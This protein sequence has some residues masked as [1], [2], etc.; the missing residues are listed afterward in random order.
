MTPLHTLLH[1]T[2]SN[3]TT[4]NHTTLHFTTLHYTSLHLLEPQLQLQLDS[5]P[6][7][8]TSLRYTSLHYIS[9]HYTNY[10]Y[11]H[12]YHYAHLHCPTLDYT[13]LS[14]IS[15]RYTSYT[16]TNTTATALRYLQHGPTT[17]PLRYS[18]N[19]SGTYATLHPAVVGEVT[20]HATIAATLHPPFRPSVDSLCQ[21]CI[22]KTNLSYRFPV[23][24]LPPRPCAVL[25]VQLCLIF[26]Y[27]PTYLLPTYLYAYIPTFAHTYIPTYPETCIP[28]Y[29]CTSYLHTYIPTSVHTY[30]C[31]YLHS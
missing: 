28:E 23:L 9:L 3:Y 22:T 5:T 25:L 7:H 19:Y 30:I 26:T 18:Y 12:N 13:T 14:Y 29:L 4:L 11:R 6:R 21:P 10:S 17:T 16:T 24:K 8:Y 2:T 1:Y 27:I 20:T 15:L 31:T